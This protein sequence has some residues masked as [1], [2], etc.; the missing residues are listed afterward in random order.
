MGKQ[1]AEL[2]KA[3]S[4]GANSFGALNIT[5]VWALFC[6]ALGGILWYD[7][8]ETHRKDIVWQRIRTDDSIADA[9]TADALHMLAEAQQ[10]TAEAQNK[11][12]II[13]DERL[14]RRG[15]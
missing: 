2:I 3:L 10:K 11:I 4:D 12:L 7:K 9:K 5:A 1:I 15:T 13:L 8:R 14:S 6:M